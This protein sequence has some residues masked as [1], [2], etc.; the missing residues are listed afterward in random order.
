MLVIFPFGFFC[1]YLLIIFM[2]LDR[3]NWY[4]A[5]SHLPFQTWEGISCWQMGLAFLK[6]S[7]MSNEYSCFKLSIF[8]NSACYQKKKTLYENFLVIFWHEE[9]Q[10]IKVRDKFNFHATIYLHKSSSWKE[11]EILNISL[12]SF[13]Y[14]FFWFYI[15]GGKN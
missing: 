5:G 4:L 7:L 10:E 8:I 13:F 6:S 11:V 12:I 9:R 1:K 3:K 14:F 15:A 2:S